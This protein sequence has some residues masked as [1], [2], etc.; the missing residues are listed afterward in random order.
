[1]VTVNG[2]VTL[3]RRWWSSPDEG[4]FAPVDPLIDAEH[5]TYTVGVLEMAA[6]LNNDG[7]SFDSTADNLRRTAQVSMSGEQLRLL[8]EAE[9][10]KVRQKQLDGRL[11]PAFQASDCVIPKDALAPVAPVAEGTNPPN[12][13]AAPS[14]ALGAALPK[15]RVYLGTDGVMAPV[16][17]EEEKIKRRKKVCLKRQ[18]RG[19]KCDPLPPR[20]RGW[21]GPY[22]EFKVMTFYDETGKYNHHVL[23]AGKR[24]QMGMRI[25]R[26]A[27]RLKFLEADERVSIVDGAT[28]IPQQLQEQPQALRLDGLGLDNYH[29]AENVHRCRR[30]VFGEKS[31]EGRTWADNVVETFTKLGFVVGWQILIVWR[32]L[33]RSPTKRKAADRLLNF[34]SERREMISY[35]EFRQRGWQIGSGPTEARCKT[36]THRL[37]ASGCRWDSGNAESVAAL[38]TL[39][40]SGQWNQ[41]WNLRLPAKT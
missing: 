38:T 39:Q 26:E 27:Q 13:A 36:T 29:F 37:K 33:L 23:C 40:D 31:T 19:R 1:M 9:G 20:R 3:R 41:H 28:W 4:S 22:R 11:T 18:Q 25:R 5:A 10:A 24:T 16:I 7:T 12:Q 17:T 32:A 21:T 34:V 30:Q 2:E 6:R 35:P 8:V 15:T 14:A